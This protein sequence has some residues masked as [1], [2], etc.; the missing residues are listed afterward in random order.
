MPKKTKRFPI[1]LM[2]LSFLAIA[3]F[4]CLRTFD[5]YELSTLD[6]RFS[7]RADQ[8]Q[9]EDIAIIEIA[10]DS[11]RKIGRW[12][13][14][15]DWHGSLINILSS[16][17]VRMII[18]DIIFSEPSG[19]DEPLV[20]A[21]EMA[22][23]VYYAYSF[24]IPEY[25][26]VEKTREARRLKTPLLDSLKNTSR[27]SGHVNVFPDIDG[28]TRKIAPFIKCDNILFT[29]LGFLAARD[30]LGESERSTKF[31]P[32]K[33]IALT[34]NNIRIPLD[35]GS[36]MF[37]NYAGR[38]IDTF[39]HYS[40][41]DI[42]KS[43]ALIQNGER[44]IIDLNDLKG[45]V[46]FIGLTGTGLHDL[47]PVPLERRYPSIGVHINT[48]NTIVTKNFLRRP[49]VPANL[50]ILL[51]LVL[52]ISFAAFKL[53]GRVSLVSALAVLSA[54]TLITLGLF[55]FFGIWIDLFYPVA[56]G[57]VIYLAFT[58]YR[59][60]LEIHKRQLIERELSVAS[61]IQAS[62]LPENPPRIKGV[63]LSADMSPAKQVG[64]DLYDFVEFSPH[65]VGIMIGDVSGKGVPAALYMAKTIS[66][67][68]LFSKLNEEPRE[69]LSKL[70]ENLAR[71]SRTNLFVTMTYI[72]Y[73]SQVR[74]LKFACGGHNPTILLRKGQPEL[75]YLDV[76][77]GIP[78]GMMESPFDQE[79]L[80]LS[81]GDKLILYTDGVSE[82][83]NK[84]GEEFGEKR[85]GDLILANSSLDAENLLLEI[86]NGVGKFSRGAPQHDD[87][88]AIVM[89]VKE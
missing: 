81:V 88:T 2:V 5:N 38:W 47:N 50:L 23:N 1:F 29:H 54:F 21:T 35:K 60:I 4:S 72:I 34:K 10:D 77:E 76:K 51:G 33:E 68:R 82:A 69:V 73:D 17:G 27:G 16:Y 74:T 26:N 44:P 18:F 40:Y 22:G 39:K 37:V 12:P 32:S 62:F 41:I 67:F 45:K 42:L 59:F 55:A 15:R 6:L 80:T 53:P 11:I 19:A 61:R 3:V 52:L 36:N 65:K 63:A 20:E 9:N 75:S 87:I 78:L 14:S 31:V 13:F 83:K 43:Y 71:E 64:G 70:N 24:D 30:Y 7:L 86:K 46:C 84:A 89:E 85:L 25:G 66:E 8:P 48:F 28:K 58:F 49:G 79:T 57:F 56:A